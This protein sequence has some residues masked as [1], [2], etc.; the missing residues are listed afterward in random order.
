M[1]AMSSFAKPWDI[2][3]ALNQV[4][5]QVAVPLTMNPSENAF[6]PVLCAKLVRL[7]VGNAP[8]S[9]Y[10]APNTLPGAGPVAGMVTV[11]G[12]LAADSL[13][14][15]SNAVTVNVWVLPAARPV[16]VARAIEAVATTAPPS[17][18]W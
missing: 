8:M 14:A 1:A 9:T 17:R 13:P 18:T 7:G 4:A 12:A 15:T 6:R 5:W 3:N 16:I 11:S 10:G 2:V